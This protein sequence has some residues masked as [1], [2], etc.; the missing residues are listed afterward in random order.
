ME[1]AITLKKKWRQEVVNTELREKKEK[2]NK[3][4]E[5][6]ERKYNINQR[7]YHYN[8]TKSQK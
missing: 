1:M 4:K 2:E 3:T 7:I 5:G 8:F 6:R